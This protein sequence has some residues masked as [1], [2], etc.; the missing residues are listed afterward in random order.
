METDTEPN[1]TQKT[2]ARLSSRCRLSADSHVSGTE[3]KVLTEVRQ[4]M[5]SNL[6]F[7]CQKKHFVLSKF[8]QD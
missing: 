8:N 6:T 3:I 1:R 4:F 7:L 2:Q 5:C